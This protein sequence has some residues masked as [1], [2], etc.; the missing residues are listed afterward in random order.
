MDATL[1]TKSIFTLIEFI[2]DTVF[3]IVYQEL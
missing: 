1:F 2:I 3:R